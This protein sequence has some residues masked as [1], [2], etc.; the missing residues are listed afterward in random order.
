L[1]ISRSK[2]ITPAGG[3]ACLPPERFFLFRTARFGTG[4]VC[5]A[6]LLTTPMAQVPSCRRPARPA[7]TVANRCGGGAGVQQVAPGVHNR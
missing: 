4:G 7:A 6:S 1:T 2:G 5:L 3:K